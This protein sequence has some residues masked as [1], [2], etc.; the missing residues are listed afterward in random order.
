MVEDAVDNASPG[1]VKGDRKY[2]AQLVEEDLAEKKFGKEFYDLDQIQQIDL[3][4]EALNGLM[5]K[6]EDDLPMAEGGI[7]RLGLKEGS[8]MTRRSFLKLLGGLAA[9]PIVGKFF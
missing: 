4:D 8:G 6:Y 3:Y 2:N 5:K 9:V 7:A 1:F